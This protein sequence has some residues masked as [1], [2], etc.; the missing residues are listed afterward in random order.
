MFAACP[1]SGGESTLEAVPVQTQ[2]ETSAQDDSLSEEIEVIHE[3]VLEVSIPESV[4]FDSDGIRISAR[5]LSDSWLIK[6]HPY[7]CCFLR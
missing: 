7:L 2:P 6:T 3:P 1:A 4:L 5:D